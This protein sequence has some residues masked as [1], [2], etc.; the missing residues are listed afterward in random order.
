MDRQYQKPRS[1]Q[2]RIIL[3]ILFSLVFSATSCGPSWEERQAK[4]E[5]ERKELIR[6][7]EAKLKRIS[8][9]VSEKHNSIYFPPKNLQ[10]TAFTYE[11][12]KFFEN[13]A[14]RAI[15]F[16]GYLEDIERTNRGIVVEFLCPLGENF[17][18]NKTAVRFKL[19]VSDAQVKHFFEGKREEI[20]LH[21]LRYFYG[22]DY[23]VVAKIADLKRTRRY[24]F[25]GSTHGEEVEINV[26]IPSSFVSTGVLIEAVRIPKD[27]S[28]TRKTR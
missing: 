10:T 5:S 22:P 12:Q 7:E 27:E 26:E 17:F 3:V 9:Q 25:G 15:L 13:Y 6:K 16:K 8:D 18:I 14:E 4:K 2:S 21:S 1:F 11:L 19:A 28:T 24:E 20:M 23:F